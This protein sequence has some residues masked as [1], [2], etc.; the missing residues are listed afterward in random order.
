[1]PAEGVIQC[2]EVREELHPA[3]SIGSLDWGRGVWDYRSYWNWASASGFL[4]DGRTVGLNLGC[5]F[6]DLSAASENCLVLD[7]SVHK[8]EQVRFDY[9]SGEYMRLW[10]FTDSQG[11]LELKFTP[12]KERVATTDLGVIYSEV[13]QMFGSYSGQVVTDEGSVVRL[14]GLVGFAEEHNAKW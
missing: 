1:M 12:Y 5:G 13:H 3:H 4:P 14:D 6:G 9:Q 2:G 11:R 8:L 7:G 10:K